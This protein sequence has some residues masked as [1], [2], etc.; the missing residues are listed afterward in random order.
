MRFEK[1]ENLASTY[2]SGG[3]GCKLPKITL[4]ICRCDRPNS[5]YLYICW[6]RGPIQG[7]LVVQGRGRRCHGS[8]R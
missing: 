6:A 7:H 5:I 2:K 3:L 4:Y 1:T 8:L